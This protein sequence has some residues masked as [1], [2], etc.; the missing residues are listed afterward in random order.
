VK[1]ITASDAEELEADHRFLSRLEDRLRIESD[2]AAW[3]IPTARDQLTP[4]ARRMGYTGTGAAQ[5]LL[6]EL[7]RRRA[8]VRAIFD[9]CFAREMGDSPAKNPV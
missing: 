8:R 6:Q 3:A 2:Q 5:Q 4:I 7:E 1:L 9:A